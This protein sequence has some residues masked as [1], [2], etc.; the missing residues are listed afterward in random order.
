MQPPML[1][2]GFRS[3][4]LGLGLALALS[5][6]A[7][8]E[9]R[10]NEHYLKAQ[11]L[12]QAG[13]MNEAKVELMRAVGIRDDAPDIWFALGQL[14]LATGELPEAFTAFG[15][16][17]EL[18]PGDA[19]TLRPLSYT[20]YMIGATRLAKDA[21]DRLLALNPSD[22]QGLAIS[23]MMALDKGEPDNAI[24][25]A[26]K[27]LAVAPTD[28]SALLL[29]ARAV[30][31]KGGVG[32]AIKLLKEAK[33]TPETQTGLNMALLQF[34][35]AN[36]DVAGMKSLFPSLIEAQKDNAELALDYANLLYKTGDI[37]NARKIWADAVLK[38]RD[39]AKFVAWAF[40]LLDN[41]EP[42][43]QPA[44]LD[45]RLTKLPG[46]PLRSAA[47]Q[48]LITRK[49]YAGALALITQGGG[50]ATND[51]GLQ[52]VA[53][54]GL[55][56][57][58]EAEGIVNN[59]LAET[60]GAQDP[61]A[62]LLR[63][64]WAIPAGKLDRA[65]ADAQGATIADPSNLAARL[66]TAQAYAAAEQPL[67]VRQ[68]LAQAVRDLPRSRRALVAYVNFLQGQGDHDGA[69][70]AARNF[71]DANT[72]QPWGWSTL[73]SACQKIND[74]GCIISAK[75]RYDAALRDYNFTNPSRP[76]K[77]RGLFS[78]LSSS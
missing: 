42:E 59:V 66:V 49:D 44:W 74:G 73:A 17:D 40:E 12:A 5:A 35:R 65:G 26:E 7:S 47:G 70:A 64:R 68:V 8:K 13:Q 69:I 19:N 38:R 25:E 30:A 9:E 4:F 48:Y 41:S 21:N 50:A 27:I 10:A 1:N 46:S 37:T 45:E 14:R 29:K 32:E 11:Q 22:P 43:A 75:K 57:R 51:R 56:R 18:R 24:A 67:R 77:M 39:D 63:A 76:F 6:C 15:R 61:N 33:T 36:G 60:G 20:G 52:A 72:A 31:V 78:P 62:L 53:L 34:Y 16:A 28:Q 3:I 2:I 55:G 23:G 54:D 71:A 58:A